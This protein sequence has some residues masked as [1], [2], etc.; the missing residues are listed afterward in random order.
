MKFQ[1]LNDLIF[2][3]LIIFLVILSWGCHEDIRDLEKYK[4]PDWLKGKILTQMKNEEDLSIFTS[5]LEKVGYDTLLNTSGSY[6]VFAPTNEAFAK[7]FQDHPE[8]NTIKD[9]PNDKLEAIVEFQIIYNAWSKEQLQTL[10]VSGWIDPDNVLS[11]PR[12]YK[13]KTLFYE[14]NKSYPVKRIGS[15]YRIVDPS[16]STGNKIAY[17]EFNK[18][19]PVFFQDFFNVYDLNYS[20]YSFYFN[21]PFEPG[22]LYFA[23]AEIGDGIQAQNGIIYKTDRVV[24]PLPNAEEILEKGFKSFSYSKFLDLVHSFSEFSV[25]LEATYDQPGAEQGLAVDTLYNLIYH[26]LILNIHNELTVGNDPRNTYSFHPGLLA[27]TDEALDSYLNEYLSLWGDFK[28][29]PDLIKRLIVNS[30][31]SKNAIYGTDITKGFINGLND[32]VL[33]N[34]NDIIQ[35]AFGSNC[36]FLGLNKAI[37]PRVITSVCRPL[38]LTRAYETMMYAC[39]DT[40]VLTALKKQNANYGFYLPPDIITGRN[41]DSSLIRN[42][43]NVELNRYYYIGKSWTEDKMKTRST[44][45]IRNQILNQITESTPDGSADKEFLRTLG[46]NYIIVNNV[47][48]TAQGTSTSKFGYEGVVGITIYPKLYQEYTDNGQ[49]FTVNGWFYFENIVSY[50]GLILTRYP[51]FLNLLE[52][53]GLYDPVYYRLKFLIDGENYTAFIPTAQALEDYRVDT[54]SIKELKDFLMYH[55]VMGELIFTDGKKPSGRYPTTLQDESSTTYNTIYS[56]LNIRPMPNTI[57]ILD[58]NGGVYLDIHENG[59]LTNKFIAYKYN[60]DPA[61]SSNWDYI[62]TGVVHEID[63]VLREDLLDAN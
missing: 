38:Y 61:S 32:S 42:I 48:G 52:K 35:K 17:T 22:K 18:Y 15:Y 63:K 20:D 47:D 14:K 55:F 49:V 51:E 10:D 33:I 16:E 46:G 36:S 37:V 9:I 21:R 31:M 45:E 41:G 8:Y 12:A 54:L 11:K 30:Y 43:T 57:Q 1:N 26:N 4:S 28:D 56:S 50:A 5:C 7:Y 6:T 59:E 62:I 13:R 29:L 60:K 23:E 58:K 44:N 39:E 34:E 19:C 25:N 53:A 2:L 27:P 24:T 3:R 40:R